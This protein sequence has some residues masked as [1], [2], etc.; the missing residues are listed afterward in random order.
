MKYNTDILGKLLFSL[1]HSQGHCSISPHH[2]S[3]RSL[4]LLKNCSPLFNDHYMTQIYSFY[5][6]AYGIGQLS[7]QPHLQDH[8][9]F[10]ILLHSNFVFSSALLSTLPYRCSSTSHTPLWF[11]SHPLQNLTSQTTVQ[12][13]STALPASLSKRC[14][15]GPHPGLW[16]QKLL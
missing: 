12:T 7:S 16:D 2:L 4:R 10:C 14:N 1:F 9:E 15:A 13:N 5:F 11:W 8:Q 6:P 3:V